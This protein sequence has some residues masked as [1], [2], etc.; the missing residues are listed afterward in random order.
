[1]LTLVGNFY[2]FSIATPFNELSDEHKKIVLYGSGSQV[3]DFSKSKEE[4]DGQV[5][6]NLLKELSQ[7]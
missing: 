2:N 1:M 7:E 3:I 5:R 6:K 4:E